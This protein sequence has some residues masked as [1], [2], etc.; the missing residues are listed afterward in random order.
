MKLMVSL[1][2]PEAGFDPAY[3]FD[4]HQ[5]EQTSYSEFVGYDGRPVSLDFVNTEGGGVPFEPPG[6]D[7]FWP[8]YES[9]Q[10]VIVTNPGMEVGDRFGLKELPSVPEPATMTLLGMG[11]LFVTARKRKLL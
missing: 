10:L 8:G 5:L 9:G 4:G 7:V 11:A 3:V 1:F 6:D 2:E